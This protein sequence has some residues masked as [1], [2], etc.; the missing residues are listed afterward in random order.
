MKQKNYSAL[1]SLMFRILLSGIIL[2]T[3]PNVTP[4]FA[5]LIRAGIGLLC[6]APAE[7]G[8]VNGTLMNVP[9][10]PLMF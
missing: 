3:G 1:V 10:S 6:F 4:W 7:A 5:E 8:V 2:F 9:H